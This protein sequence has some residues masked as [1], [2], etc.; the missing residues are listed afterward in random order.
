MTDALSTPGPK[1][2]LQRPPESGP[3][4]GTTEWRK[5][6]A[7]ETGR[8]EAEL[9]DK[10]RD[11]LIAL[12]DHTGPEEEAKEAPKGVKVVDEPEATGAR[13]RPLWMTPVEG[14]Y[15]VEADVLTAE[16]EEQRERTAQRHEDALTQ[17]DAQKNR[18]A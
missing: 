4:S 18:K 5:F 15:A 11:Q 17:L 8:S 3:G 6:A 14:G 12:V 2:S 9:A 13:G 7:Q 1:G 16:F 10:S